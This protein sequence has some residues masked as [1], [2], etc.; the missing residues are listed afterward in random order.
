MSTASPRVLSP[1][2]SAR[3]SGSEDDDGDVY[4][5]SINGRPFAL[6]GI[7][8]QFSPVKRDLV[9]HTKFRFSTPDKRR[10]LRDNRR[11]NKPEPSKASKIG[12]EP[13]VQAVDVTLLGALQ[14]CRSQAD[15]RQASEALAKRLSC[16]DALARKVLIA[17]VNRR[18]VEVLRRGWA[19]PEDAEE[20]MKFLVELRTD[21]F[22]S[23][24]PRDVDRA[25]A[26]ALAG[27]GALKPFGSVQEDLDSGLQCWV[28]HA[29]LLAKAAEWGLLKA[30]DQQR[31][32]AVMVAELRRRL[33]GASPEDL[34]CAV[35]WLQAGGSC[36][37]RAQRAV[38]SADGANL[39]RPAPASPSGQGNAAS[40]KDHVKVPQV[41]REV[42]DATFAA[43]H[44]A[45]ARLGDG[46]AACAAAAEALRQ[47]GFDD[48]TLQPLKRAASEGRL[49]TRSPAA[50]GAPSPA[51]LV[52]AAAHAAGVTLPPV[53]ASP[54][55]AS[56]LRASAS[57]LRGPGLGGSVSSVDLARLKVHS[58]RA[59]LL[60]KT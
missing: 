57:S 3:G 54:M 19:T 10:A 36:L 7:A 60:R 20:A 34:A 27:L 14:D 39:S 46:S 21:G 16:V 55:R 47:A 18:I 51:E 53:Q 31:V 33:F 5:G 59:E 28:R 32:D 24:R 56:P 37:L 42:S 41:T 23:A 43:L 12:S 25:V 6:D 9:S 2:L 40:A 4:A 8:K 26:G 48:P 11:R 50:E 35:H 58:M 44:T 22:F 29:Q 30:E 52:H 45:E 15:I 13:I 1:G 17:A 38:A 49:A